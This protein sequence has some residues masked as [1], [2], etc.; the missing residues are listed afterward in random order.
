MTEKIISTIE[1]YGMLKGGERVTAA[2]SGGADS[3]CLLLV[4]NDLKER[5]SLKLDAVHV[6][7]CIRGEEADRDEQ[8][9]RKLCERLGVELTVKKIDVPAIAAEKK[10]SLEEAARNVRYAVFAE[11]SEEGLTAT[12]HTASDNA[13]TVLLNL[14]RGTGLKGMCGIPPV[15]D[16]IIRPL[17]DVTRQDV[18]NYLK[19]TGQDFVTDSTNLDND[20]TRNRIRHNIIPEILRINSGF[21]KTFCAELKIFSEENIFI[22]NSVKTAYNICID[23][24]ALC[25]LEKY[26][27]VIRKRCI[28]IFLRENSLP[29]SAE[30]INAVNDI[31]DS[32]GKI[33]ISDGVF[34]VCR[35][36]IL[37]ILRM[38]EKTEIQPVKLC[39][40][41]NSIFPHKTVFAEIKDGSGG[42]I[43][44]DKVCG[45][46]VLRSR[47]NGDR[48]QL[49][50]RSFTSSVKK[51]LNE[52]I[53]PDIRP[54]IHFLADDTGVIFIENIGVADRVKPD[55]NTRKSLYITVLP[56]SHEK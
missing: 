8:F 30:K 15:R 9:C 34:A 54:Y 5:Y 1:T 35:K 53:R 45:D 49:A 25:G 40:G 48:I 46:I 41:E 12:A 32:G 37:T 10:Q 28:S 7:H 11:H 6:N 47:R 22:E 43:D 20:Y 3:V 56:T 31:L 55:G 29:V 39:C 17:I 36:H 44:T 4:L 21:Y 24:G 13:E 2:L 26:D 33:N 23:N 52:K 14:A 19:E 51:L 50:G 27:T 18:E 42:I 16:S 38:P